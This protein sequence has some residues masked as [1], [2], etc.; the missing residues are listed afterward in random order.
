MFS[1]LPKNEQKKSTLLLWYLKSNCFRS[2]FGR[3]EDTKN[4]FQNL[5]TLNKGN[6]GRKKSQKRIKNITLLLGTSE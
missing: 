2:L 6:V 3:I 5:L 4:T 1:I